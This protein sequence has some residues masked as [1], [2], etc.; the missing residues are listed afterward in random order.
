MLRY[1][2]RRLLS[3]AISLVVA[4]AVIFAVVEVIPGDP[5]SYMLGL[6]VAEDTVAALRAELGLDQPPLWRYFNW[7]AGMAAGD[8]GISY[9]YRTPVAE[10]VSDR[11]WVSLPLTVYALALSTAIAIPAG[12][13]AASKRGGAADY[14]VMGVT[15]LG[16]AVPNFWFAI[17]LV[18]VFAISLRWVSAGGFPGWDGGPLPALKSLTLP[19]I[20]L[21]LPQASILARVMRSSLLDTLDEPHLLWLNGAI[22]LYTHDDAG[23][24]RDRFERFRAA[25]DDLDRDSRDALDADVVEAANWLATAFGLPPVA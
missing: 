13:L 15:Q 2:A 6:N 9:T 17:L 3:L 24:A 4:S 19:A 22:S 12:L 11:L 18:I 8:F 16:V 23:G 14:G 7:I 25:V 5:A 21:A 10:L 1:A 20:A